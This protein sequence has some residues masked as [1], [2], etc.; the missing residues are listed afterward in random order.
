MGL[1]APTV[2][3]GGQFFEMFHDAGLMVSARKSPGSIQ[4]RQK[5]GGGL[6]RATKPSHESRCG[7]LIAKFFLQSP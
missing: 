2:L 3:Q 4:I 1:V 5:P 6:S 7:G